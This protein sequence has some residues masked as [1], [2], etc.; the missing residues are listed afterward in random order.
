MSVTRGHLS[1]HA[2][3]LSIRASQWPP[4]PVGNAKL[5]NGPGPTALG[6]SHLNVGSGGSAGASG[7]WDPH[8][9]RSAKLWLRSNQVWVPG[10]ATTASVSPCTSLAGIASIEATTSGADTLWIAVH[11]PSPK[12]PASFCMVPYALSDESIEDVRDAG[13]EFYSS[14]VGNT[15][16]NCDVQ[17]G[18]WFNF[19]LKIAGE[20]HLSEEFCMW[21]NEVMRPL[22]GTCVNDVR[23]ALGLAEFLADPTV[24]AMAW[25]LR[26]LI[27][28]PYSRDWCYDMLVRRWGIATQQLNFT[29]P[30]VR[31]VQERDLERLFNKA[32]SQNP[33]H[34]GA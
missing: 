16:S 25:H 4:Q 28:M 14:T 21:P 26:N 29:K 24:A 8:S 6:V 7:A 1:S 23:A 20:F 22:A 17:Q 5:A 15:Y 31:K 12:H 3:Q 19:L 27:R 32:K 30:Y 18:D 10:G 13:A 33:A 34:A 11:Q 9:S 2:A